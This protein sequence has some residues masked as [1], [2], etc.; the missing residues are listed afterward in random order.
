MRN[1][2]VVTGQGREERGCVCVVMAVSVMG[3][4]V[5]VSGLYKDRTRASSCGDMFSGSM[6]A[7]CLVVYG[8]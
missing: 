7:E 8:T 4:P 2:E 5:V 3:K 6:Y 1:L